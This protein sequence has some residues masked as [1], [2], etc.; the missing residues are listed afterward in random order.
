MA[1]LGTTILVG[2]VYETA[3]GHEEAGHA[4]T[5][6]AVTG[7]LL[8]TLTSP[9]AQ[10]YGEFGCSVAISDVALVVGAYDETTL[11]HFEAGH[12]YVF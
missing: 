9:H 1:I 2:A 11:G 10:S 3:L 8:S 7:D 4:Y 6:S 12:A 5:F